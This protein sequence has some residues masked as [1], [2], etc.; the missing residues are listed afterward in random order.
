MPRPQRKIAG[1]SR[2]SMSSSSSSYSS[3][4]YPSSSSGSYSS[5]S[6]PSLYSNY[7]Y[8]YNGY[9][10]GY[11]YS[12]YVPASRQFGG[13]ARKGTKPAHSPYP[14]GPKY[15]VVHKYPTLV[16]QSAKPQPKPRR[17]GLFKSMGDSC[18]VDAECGRP[19]EGLT[20]NSGTCGERETC[21]HFWQFCPKGKMCKNSQCVPTDGPTTGG[22]NRNAKKRHNKKK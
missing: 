15:P 11:G 5:S 19:G 18:H 9:N 3:S 10:N 2:R 13:A 1:V 7:G 12:T 8:G 14:A 21:G 6:A 4:S 17:G 22:F 20:C 16:R